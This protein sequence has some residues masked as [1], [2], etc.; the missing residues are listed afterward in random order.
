MAQ[1]RKST[2]ESNMAKIFLIVENGQWAYG[3]IVPLVAN[4]VFLINI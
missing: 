2:D 4:W 3:F 1:Q